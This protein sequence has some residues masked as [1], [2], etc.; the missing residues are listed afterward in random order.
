MSKSSLEFK[1]RYFESYSG[2]LLDEDVLKDFLQV[3]EHDEI[4]NVITIL[5]KRSFEDKKRIYKLL[6]IINEQSIRIEKLEN[7][8]NDKIIKKSNGIDNL[9]EEDLDDLFDIEAFRF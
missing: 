5:I 1:D 2:M 6:N 7:L 9:S 4:K 3:Q 8:S